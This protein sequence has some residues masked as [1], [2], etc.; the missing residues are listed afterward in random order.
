MTRTVRDATFEV[1][2][3]RGLTTIFSNP[4][5]TEVPFLAGLPDDLRFVLGLHEGSVL[6]MATGYAL[7]R[8]EPALV[9]VHT[10]AGLGDSVGGIATARVNRAPLVVIV[11]QQDRRHL[12]FEPFLTGRLRGLAG[13]YPVWVDEPVRAQ[14][15]PARSTAPSTK[16][17]RRVARRSSSCPWTTGCRKPTSSART[18]RP[19]G[20][21]EP[22][23]STKGRS[24]SWQRS[25]RADARRRSSW[26]R[27][28]TGPRRGRRSSSWRSASPHLSSRSPSVPTPAS[29]RTTA[30]SRAS[31]G[32]PPSPAGA[33]RSLR[34]RAGHRRGR[35]PPVPMD[36]RA[37]H[38][39]GHTPRTRQRRPGRG[40]PQ[41]C[42]A[43][44]RRAACGGRSSP[45]PPVAAAGRRP[46]RALSLSAAAR[47]AGAWRA[48]DRKPRA[49]CAR[50][51]LPE[52]AIVLEEA[53]VDRPEIHD[54]LLARRPLGYVSAAMGGLGFGVPAA[55]GLRMALP[56]RPVVAVLGDGASLYGIQ[57]L[58]SAAHYGAGVLYV[59]LSNGGYVIMDRLAE[60]SGDVGPWPGFAEIDI[61]A[62]ARGFCCPAQRVTSHDE[63][64]AALDEA[65]PTL[66]TRAAAAARRR[67]RADHHVRSLT[68][69]GAARAPHPTALVCKNRACCG[70]GVALL[71]SVRSVLYTCA[72]CP[73]DALVEPPR[74]S[75]TA[76]SKTRAGTRR[77]YR[78]HRSRVEVV[79]DRFGGASASRRS[80]PGRRQA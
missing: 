61:A 5:S 7:G 37:L 2:R 9:L 45:C 35:V 56:N 54:R 59:I 73:R 47:P 68:K 20:C 23:Q 74:V 8:G 1:F 51:R 60:R 30:C 69:E 75:P 62:L 41:P 57:G 12:V 27:A 49:R 76:H 11:G 67:D 4:G 80:Q 14:D 17:S 22:M 29:H 25:S 66:R 42:R 31:A 50:G 65:I 64:L 53:P 43:G 63:L 38:R 36:A 33:A 10:T 26:A 48:A 70:P 40:A 58:W 77:R 13:D 72:R 16:R 71:D 32:G 18:H 44:G 6:G 3:R 21:C 52:E 15:V 78:Q 34:R 28:R 24:R 79:A 55:A 39:G 19:D 46:A